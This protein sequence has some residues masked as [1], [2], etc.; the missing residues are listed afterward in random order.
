MLDGSVEF[1]LGRLSRGPVTNLHL[2]NHPLSADELQ[3]PPAVRAQIE[4]LCARAAGC[5]PGLRC[6]GIDILLERG[7]LQ[8]RII[9]M[10][11]QGDLIY[12]DI[13][14]ENRIY[15]RQAQIMAEWINL[16]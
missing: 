1:L 16:A 3:I 7:S 5:Y 10:N 13:F 14:H 6:A 11:A 2:N 4:E 12:Q 15:R 9:E 8:P